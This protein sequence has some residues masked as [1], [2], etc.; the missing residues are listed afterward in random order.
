MRKSK[1][2][3]IIIA[4]IL[5]AAVAIGYSLMDDSIGGEQNE[6]TTAATGEGVPESTAPQVPDDTKEPD[7][8]T[9]ETVP[10]ETKEPI[11]LSENV[12]VY[13]VEKDPNEVIIR[14]PKIDET[15]PEYIDVPGGD[16]Y[17]STEGIVYRNDKTISIDIFDELQGYTRTITFGYVTGQCNRFLYLNPSVSGDPGTRPYTY[18]FS[19]STPIGGGAVL[20]IPDETLTSKEVK[21]WSMGRALEI[22]EAAH[23]TAP[24]TPGTVW[25]ASSPVDGPVYIDVRLYLQLDY[26]ATVRLTIDK[27]KD[28]T[29]SIVNLENRNLL[30]ENEGTDYSTSELAYVV[31]LANETIHDTEKMHQYYSTYEKYEMAVEDCIITLQTLDTGLYYNQ[32]IPYKGDS[33]CRYYSEMDIPVLAVTYRRLG[34]GAQ[35]LYFQAIRL[36]RDGN[37]GEYY[38]I[39]RDF[40]LFDTIDHLTSQGYSGAG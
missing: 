5:V 15:H 19:F 1:L 13:Q 38:Y 30:Q 14:D 26:C 34:V 17:S 39:G 21:S 11:V 23:Y 40:P 6:T 22:R 12:T 33:D 37:H 4:I 35:T 16:P 24:N 18:Y 3:F 10:N 7:A 9:E 29:Y 2:I 8:E 28:G 36:P 32:F 31:G 20:T 25:L 27:D